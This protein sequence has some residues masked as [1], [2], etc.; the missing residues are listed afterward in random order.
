MAKSL[1]GGFPIGA[2]WVREPY[3]E[4]LGPGT[5][6]ST[7]GG[8]PLGCAVALKVFEVIEREQLAENARKVGERLLEALTELTQEFP[9]VLKGARGVGLMLGIELA[10][11]V[12]GLDT[13][14]KAPSL[15]FVT[16]LHELGLLTIPSGTHVVR[17]LP[18]L[19][20]TQMQAEE[21]LAIIQ[22]LTKSLADAGA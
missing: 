22:K 3:S 2:F 16:R 20:L 13:P 7:F 6:A 4:L 18:P 15:Q 21:G 19:N 14:N 8:T 10:P 9:T 17:L 12:P 5:H 1:G 11:Q